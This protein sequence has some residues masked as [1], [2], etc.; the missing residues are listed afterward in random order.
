[1]LMTLGG[2]R[3]ADEDVIIERCAIFERKFPT[4]QGW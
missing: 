2:V 1:V 3:V 4:G